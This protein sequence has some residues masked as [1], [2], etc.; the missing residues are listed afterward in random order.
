MV[1]LARG[2]AARSYT[3]ENQAKEREGRGGKKR[4]GKG[5]ERGKRKGRER[6]RKGNG[7]E[8][9]IRRG[10][11]KKRRQRYNSGFTIHSVRFQFT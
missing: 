11:E 9:E 10:E 1:N 5:R 4:K 8:K 2:E 7:R 3:L 6:G